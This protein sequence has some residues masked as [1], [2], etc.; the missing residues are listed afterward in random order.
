MSAAAE[1]LVDAPA[2][3]AAP[4]S[5]RDD[6]EL[7]AKLPA[8]LVRLVQWRVRFRPW[9]ERLANR[10]EGGAFFSATAREM[11]RAVDGVE[12]GAYSYGGCFV[13]GAFPPGT[14]IG[15]WCSIADDVRALG[16]NHPMGQLSMHPF[17]YNAKLGVVP[18]DTVPFAGLV[19][20]DDVWIGLRAIL[21]PGCTRVG[22]GAVI[23]AGAVVTKDVPDFAV[24]AGA[25]A[26]VIRHRFAEDVQDAIR[27]SRWWEKSLSELRM[28]SEL[29][30]RPVDDDVMRHPLLAGGFEGAATG[31]A[32]ASAR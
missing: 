2:R 27:R 17:F 29:F 10:Y 32:P 8:A 6:P 24:V 15:R 9:V 16:R 28:H 5:Y 13:S 14:R 30:T 11:M 7:T 19:I 25:P 3:P 23:A 4:A 22:L 31:A 21:T 12:I 1:A 26:R 18:R 20:G